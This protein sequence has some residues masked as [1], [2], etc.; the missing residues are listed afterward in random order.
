MAGGMYDVR[1]R[2]VMESLHLPTFISTSSCNVRLQWNGHV[3]HSDYNSDIV[4]SLLFSVWTISTIRFYYFFMVAYWICLVGRWIDGMTY[5]TLI[6]RT[7]AWHNGNCIA[8]NLSASNDICLFVCV[9][10]HQTDATKRKRMSPIEKNNTMPESECAERCDVILL[11][12]KSFVYNATWIAKCH[13]FHFIEFIL[14]HLALENT[15]R[16]KRDAVWLCKCYRARFVRALWMN[17]FTFSLISLYLCGKLYYFFPERLIV[18][19]FV[20]LVNVFLRCHYQTQSL[21][22]VSSEQLSRLK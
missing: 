2:L 17:L 15:F 4:V 19:M 9:P 8:E 7:S 11:N 18:F 20:L 5:M 10:Q 16:A 3:C 22:I 14:I 6:R 21:V 13:L 1:T 12:I